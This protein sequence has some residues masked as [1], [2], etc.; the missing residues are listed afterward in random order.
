[1]KF[2]TQ[3]VIAVAAMGI[4]LADRPAQPNIVLILT[5]DLGWQDVGCYDI[6]EPLPVETPNLDAFAK[7]GVMFWQGYSPAPT[8]APS[9]CAILS[10][11]HPAR[12]Q[13]TH[14]VGGAPPKPYMPNSRMIDPWYSGRMPED[15]LTIAKIL[16]K[17][18]YVTGHSGKWHIAIDHH[19][20]P[21]PLDV[22]FDWTRSTRGARASMPDR[23]AGFA[24]TEKDDPFRLDPAGYPLHQTNEDALD[25][26]REQQG[27]DKPFF[28]YYATWLV[29]S[30]IQTRSE[31][32]LKKY[33]EKLGADPANTPKL[34]T[35]G[36]G[37]PFYL[38]MIEEIDY[39]MGQIFDYLDQTDDPRWP[40]HKLSEN[41]YI[42]FT[43]DNGGMEGSPKE[44][45]TDNRPLSRGKISAMEG[46][47]RVPLMIAGPNIPT[48]VQSD[49]LANGLDFYPTIL[50]MAGVE[51]P[52]DKVL[53]GCDLLPLLTGDPTDASLV[54]EADGS[55]R[56]TMVW[57]FPHVPA[58][59]STIRVG[60]YKLV[61]NHSH[62]MT[63]DVPYELYRLYD[64]GERVD[65]EEANN[66]ADAEPE[67]VAE[68][69]EKLMSILGGM[70]ASLPY[71]NPHIGL[72]LPHKKKVCVATGHTAKG[73]KVTFTY[74]ER[75]AK[76]VRADLIYSKNGGHRYEEW[77]RMQ[78]EISAPGEV[79][80]VLPKGTTHYYLNLVDENRFLRSYPEVDGGRGKGFTASAIAFQKPQKQ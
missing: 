55:V 70:E 56:D 77:H 40:G 7:R 67:R 79:S 42:I 61:R 43:S 41:T 72:D 12:A 44:R 19:A 57:H 23:L 71:Y 31:A 50:S 27:S 54:K 38:A 29:H 46:G 35:P 17:N 18:G 28:L 48:E 59:E 60:D 47:T 13:K 36:Q 68:M 26:M 64:G 33:V 9:R 51:K 73:R 30:P 24:T 78:A 2:L 39:Y 4:A 21:Q 25:F 22:G 32:L 52:A 6:D 15:T 45:Y 80:V 63:P 14:V 66:L 74:K 1:M 53:D 3:I 20:F 37:N 76:V 69:D 65:I 5:D 49:V 62:V 10:G 8:C 16:S 58:Q 11:V 34:D 75:G